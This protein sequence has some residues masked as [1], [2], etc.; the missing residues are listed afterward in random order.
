MKCL[1]CWPGGRSSENDKVLYLR[2]RDRRELLVAVGLGGLALAITVLAVLIL[3]H[4]CVITRKW[5]LVEN[6]VKIKS[7][8]CRGTWG[9]GTGSGTNVMRSFRGQVSGE[10][11]YGG[12][13]FTLQKMEVH[14]C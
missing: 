10:E 9:R 2:R 12:A 13:D 6:F 14:G 7:V 5:V 11:E 1:T 3:F 8:D 4:V